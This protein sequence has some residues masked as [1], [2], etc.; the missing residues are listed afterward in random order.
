METNKQLFDKII[1]V[2]RNK[3]II[4]FINLSHELRTPLNVISSV[5]QL[6]TNL[7]KSPKR[8]IKR[9]DR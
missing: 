9:K 1:E 2:E 6:I 7:N 4:T 8:N 5:E 3:K